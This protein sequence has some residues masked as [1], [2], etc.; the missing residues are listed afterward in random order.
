MPSSPPSKI[1]RPPLKPTNQLESFIG[2]TKVLTPDVAAAIKLINDRGEGSSTSPL[3]GTAKGKLAHFYRF[4]ELYVGATLKAD[5]GGKFTFQD[6]PIPF[7]DTITMALFPK[8]GYQHVAPDVQALVDAFDSLFSKLL[9][10]L[11]TAWQT[12]N[13]DEL[14]NN[15]VELM[16]QL[17]VA[18]DKIMQKPLPLAVGG[19]YGPDFRYLPPAQRT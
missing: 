14:D 8:G 19:F 4:D 10:P 11:D 15:A 6:P 9:D 2:V 3:D 13:Q 18:A 12:G 17:E 16:E 1:T 5:A 7:P